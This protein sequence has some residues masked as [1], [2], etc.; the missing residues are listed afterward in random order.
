MTRHSETRRLIA[1]LAA[2]PQPGAIEGASPLVLGEAPRPAERFADC[3]A[4]YRIKAETGTPF[5]HLIDLFEPLETKAPGPALTDPHCCYLR[6]II[7]Y[8]RPYICSPW[9]K[10]WR[11]RGRLVANSSAGDFA[12]WGQIEHRFASGDIVEFDG[13]LF[14]VSGGRVVWT[15]RP[16]DP[17]GRRWWMHHGARR[18][19]A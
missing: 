1:A 18:V 7:F 5:R 19:G 4:A 6:S 3:F 17:L 10:L 9:R 8:C 16:G 2:M 12:D 15:A 14:E 11:C 13:D